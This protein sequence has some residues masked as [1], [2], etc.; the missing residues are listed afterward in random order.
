MLSVS[1]VHA[2][3]VEEIWIPLSESVT[4]IYKENFLLGLNYLIWL[5]SFWTKKNVKIFGGYYCTHFSVQSYNVG[6]IKR[7]KSR[8]QNKQY[9]STWPEVCLCTVVSFMHNHL[10]KE[11]LHLTH[12]HN[13]KGRAND[14]LTRSLLISLA[15]L[16]RNIVW[17][18][19]S[20]MKKTIFL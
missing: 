20:C 5:S 14:L 13:K 6:I 18:A 19:T 1:V 8:Q 12:T 11:K 16:W 10:R 15:Y 7:Q 17:C 3:K 4:Q 2:G 9:N